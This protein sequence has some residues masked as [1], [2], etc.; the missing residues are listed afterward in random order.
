MFPRVDFE[1]LHAL[2]GAVNLL[3]R[4]GPLFDQAMRDH[5]RDCS[6]EE[7]QDSVVNALKADPELVNPI[8]QKVGFGSP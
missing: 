4:D 1:P 5:R 6:V 3:R 2:N 7:V 8:A